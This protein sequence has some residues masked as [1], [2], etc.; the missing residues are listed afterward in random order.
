MCARV[1]S[2]RNMV[3]GGWFYNMKNQMCDLFVDVYGV[4]IYVDIDDQDYYVRTMWAWQRK[5]C[6]NLTRI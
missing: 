2:I 5:N 6:T 4:H 3:T 1:F